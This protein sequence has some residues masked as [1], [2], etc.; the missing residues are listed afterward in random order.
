PTFSRWQK[1]SRVR[2]ARS[3]RGTATGRT[4]AS[5]RI[6]NLRPLTLL[7]PAVPLSRGICTHPIEQILTEPAA[8]AV[9]RLRC[10][11]CSFLPLWQGRCFRCGDGHIGRFLPSR[12]R[13]T[14][15]QSGGA[16]E[17]L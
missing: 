9:F 17:T 11:G 16:L 8:A 14:A 7:T 12:R 1:S 4:K 3:P 5:P 10:P 6:F 13:G 2:R 15:K